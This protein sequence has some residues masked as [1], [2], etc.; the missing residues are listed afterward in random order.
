VK[1]RVILR[2]GA[3]I[4]VDVTEFSTGRNLVTGDLYELKW[5]FNEDEKVKLKYIRPDDVAAVLAIHE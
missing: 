3:I 2:S 5:E 1:M 4:D